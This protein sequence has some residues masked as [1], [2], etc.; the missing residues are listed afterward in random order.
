[1][2]T[3]D[4]APPGNDAAR[5]ARPEPRPMAGDEDDGRRRRR[6]PGKGPFVVLL[7]LLL[8]VGAGAVA[9]VTV[10]PSADITVT[11]H[12]ETIG[13]ISFTVT[14]DPAATAVDPAAGVIPAT[15]LRIPVTASG[16]FQA[17]GRKVVKEAATGAVR[18]SNCDPSAAYR[19]PSGTIVQTRSGIGFA[20]DEEVFLPVAVISGTPPNI[21]VRCTTS[22]VTVTAAQ[23]GAEGNVDAGTIRVV[24]ARYNRNLVRVTNPAATKGGSRQEFPRVKQEDVDAAIA[25]LKTDTQAQF[26]AALESPGTVPEG[27]TA[28]PETAAMTALATDVDP[29]TL[30]GQEVASFQLAMNGTGTVQAVDATP[31][32][33]IAQE[34]LASSII[35]GFELVP[36]SISVD[37]GSGSV[38]GGVISF[39]VDGTAKQVRPL[40]PAALER[41]VLGLPKAAAEAALA[42]YGDVVVVLWPGYVSSVPTMDAR[43]TLVVNDPVDVGPAPASPSPTAPPAASPA[44]PSPAVGSPSPFATSFPLEASPSDGG[45]SEPVPSG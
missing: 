6:G 4:P 41:Q 24:P 20:V 43:V 7:V 15:T 25:Q 37:V 26:E 16:E 27:T 44:E 45:P 13:P 21:A 10:V 22:E 23:A 8:V 9:A 39:P 29:T 17:T 11:P 1:M 12:I 34:R 28:F 38:V 36:D 32:E 35:D 5:L 42:P 14:A 31:I 30:V 33:A 2:P 19:I 40:D 18:F 3:P